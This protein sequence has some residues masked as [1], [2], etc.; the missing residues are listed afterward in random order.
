MPKTFN[1]SIS[2]I[3]N[4]SSVT[5]L[6]RDNGHLSE[7]LNGKLCAND[8]RVLDVALFDGERETAHKAIVVYEQ[9]GKQMNQQLCGTDSALSFIIHAVS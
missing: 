8:C 9:R 5:A 6:E 3:Q 1:Y 4:T 7:N 2:H